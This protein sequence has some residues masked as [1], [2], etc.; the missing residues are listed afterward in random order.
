MRIVLLGPPGSGKG[1]QAKMVAENYRVPHISTGEILR[2]IVLE[3][4][5]I[6]KKI[7]STMKSGDLVSD[8]IVIDAVVAKLR[9]PESR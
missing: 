7:A 3:K 9:S 8:E 2:A 6:G 5:S 1:T 4:T